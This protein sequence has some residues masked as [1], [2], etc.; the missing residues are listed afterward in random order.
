METYF[1]LGLSFTVKLM[2]HIERLEEPGEVMEC[3][4]SLGIRPAYPGQIQELIA[5]DPDFEME[6]EES[7]VL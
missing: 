7:D 1:P 6:A 4:E 3:R 5:Q 2:N